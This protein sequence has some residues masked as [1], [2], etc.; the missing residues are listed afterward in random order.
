MVGKCCPRGTW[1]SAHSGE[2]CKGPER[3]SPQEA[4]GPMLAAS[5]GSSRCPASLSVSRAPPGPRLSQAPSLPAAAAAGHVTARSARGELLPALSPL[6]HRVAGG[7]AAPR[8]SFLPLLLSLHSPASPALSHRA[9]CRGPAAA[10]LSSAAHRLP[11][12]PA[13]TT[14]TRRM[15]A[16][17]G[18]AGGGRLECRRLTR[19]P[20]SP[21]EGQDRAL[22]GPPAPERAGSPQR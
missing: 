13:P 8:R 14:S 19:P 3:P 5:R 2:S 12:S 7:P 10:L 21:R 9:R 11:V 4:G 16:A 6:S 17:L 20:R 18:W 1:E 15:A 22:G